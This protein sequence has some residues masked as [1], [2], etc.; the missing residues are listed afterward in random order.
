MALLMPLCWPAVLCAAGV[1]VLLHGL[2]EGWGWGGVGPSSLG[3][4]VW[5]GLN[6]DV[7]YVH[8]Q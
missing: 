5:C 8:I 1:I 6:M 3:S 2:C 4:L 7:H